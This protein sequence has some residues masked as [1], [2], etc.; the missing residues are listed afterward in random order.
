[1]CNQDF[2]SGAKIRLM[3]DVHAGAGCTIGTTMTIKDKIVPNL[4]GVD[5]GCGMETLVIHKDSDVARNFSG[6]VLDNIIRKNIPSG[7]DIRKFPHDYVSE[8]EWDKVKGKYNKNI[9]I[10]IKNRG[11]SH[12][13]RPTFSIQHYITSE[14]NRNSTAKCRI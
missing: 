8:V 6:A 10:I 12:R 11:A 5:I 4:V 13:L 14:C 9:R 7:F 1:M 2:T 3:P